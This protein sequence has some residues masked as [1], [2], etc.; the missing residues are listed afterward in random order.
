MLSTSPPASLSCAELIPPRDSEHILKLQVWTAVKNVGCSFI[1]MKQPRMALLE[2][3]VY[4]FL[5]T[6]ENGPG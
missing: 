4:L 1:E 6:L 5:Y 2:F 3:S